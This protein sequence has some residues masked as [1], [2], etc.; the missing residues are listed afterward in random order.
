MCKAG[1]LGSGNRSVEGAR[2]PRLKRKAEARRRV[3]AE[4]GTESG[5]VKVGE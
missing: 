1:F 3:A 2:P 4:T 5:S